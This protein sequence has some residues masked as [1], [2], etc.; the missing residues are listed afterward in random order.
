MSALHC[1]VL[2]VDP[3]TE[4]MLKD[5]V[6]I[7]VWYSMLKFKSLDDFLHILINVI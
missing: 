4:K 2:E 7:F 5:I 1:D 6:S 3:L